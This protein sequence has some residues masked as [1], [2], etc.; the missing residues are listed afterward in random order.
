M[1]STPS[2]T[3]SA[4]IIISAPIPVRDYIFRGGANDGFHEAIGDFAALNATTPTYLNQIGL[5]DRIPGTEED[6]PFLLKMA[7]DK[8][9]F[10]PFGLLIDKWRW[11]VFSG[12]TPPEKYNNSWWALRTRYQGVAP[13]APRPADAFDPGAKY[14]IPGNTPYARYFLAFIYE[15]QFYRAACREAG[16]QGPLNRCSVF[17]NKA[18]GEKLNALLQMG[19]ARPWPETLAAFTGESDIDASA[20]RDYFAPL[21]A[22]LTE[23]NRGRTCGW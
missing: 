23:Q 1:I 7:L 17:G 5:S 16:W 19:Q 20:I 8:I 18:V 21:D 14:H 3:S 2:I 13:P 10:L 9:A 12:A 4:T 22:W 15:F 6:I 11:D